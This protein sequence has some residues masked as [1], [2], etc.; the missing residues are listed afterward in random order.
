MGKRSKYRKISFEIE[1]EF[2]GVYTVSTFYKGIPF[3]FFTR[4]S[5][6]YDN[7][8]NDKHPEKKKTARAQVYEAI[9]KFYRQ[10]YMRRR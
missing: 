3:S 1:E 4:R 2:Y 8:D 7:I 6:W 9:K 10:T 5:D